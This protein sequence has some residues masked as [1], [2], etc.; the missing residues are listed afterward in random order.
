MYEFPRKWCCKC[1]LRKIDY[2][3]IQ[4]VVMFQLYI[5][6]LH[7]NGILLPTIIN[8]ISIS[9]NLYSWNATS[10]ISLLDLH[11]DTRRY[12]E[13]WCNVIAKYS[14]KKRSFFLFTKSKVIR[15]NNSLHATGFTMGVALQ[16][17]VCKALRINI[18]HW[19]T[20]C[21]DRCGLLS[22][23]S[24]VSTILVGI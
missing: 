17:S 15:S 10:G 14:R 4:S 16:S 2:F 18:K 24:T 11:T 3:G 8:P 12:K 21:S 23:Q 19:P 7:C 6:L 1:Q 13:L 22:N 9:N 5:L 20:R